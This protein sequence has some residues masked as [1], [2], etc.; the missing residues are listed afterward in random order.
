MWFLAYVI[1]KGHWAR[2]SPLRHCVIIRIDVVLY[3]HTHYVVMFPQVE[4]PTSRK[5]L[6]P[7]TQRITCYVNLRCK[8]G[9]LKVNYASMFGIK[10]A[11]TF[12]LLCGLPK[13][14]TDD[15]W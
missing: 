15:I 1:E 2:D 5:H 3:T 10:I 6:Y 11:F 7:D 12:V 14:N 13:T 4:S 8:T 9:T